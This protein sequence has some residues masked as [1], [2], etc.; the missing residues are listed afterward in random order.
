M[1]PELFYKDS[2]N[3]YL[4]NEPFAVDYWSLGIVLYELISGSY[5]FTGITK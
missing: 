1:A 5:P 3:P 4:T 2:D